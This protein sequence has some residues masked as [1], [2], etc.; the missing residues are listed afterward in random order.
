M[1]EIKFKSNT[2]DNSKS[3]FENDLLRGKEG[4]RIIQ[5]FYEKRRHLASISDAELRKSKRLYLADVSNSKFYQDVDVDFLLTDMRHFGQRPLI[6]IEVKWDARIAQTGNMCIEKQSENLSNGYKS[7][8]WCEKTKSDYLYYGDAKNNIFYVMETSYL[9]EYIK[10]Y[11]PRE[12]KF[13]TYETSP[14]NNKRYKAEKTVYL[15]K[16]QKIK[17]CYILDMNTYE[18]RKA[19][20]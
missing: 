6:K 7:N 4:E 20:I 1:K 10:K 16:P 17:D 14:I 15:I 19:A 18:K 13:F 3:Q 8:G 5:D 2:L 11:K 9:K 12:Y